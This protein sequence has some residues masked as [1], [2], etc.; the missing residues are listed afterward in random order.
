MADEAT[1]ACDAMVILVYSLST[2][3]NS[4]KGGVKPDRVEGTLCIA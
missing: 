4:E 2:A 3:I 1:L